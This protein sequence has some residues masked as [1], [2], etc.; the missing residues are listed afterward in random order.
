MMNFVKSSSGIGSLELPII[1]YEDD[2]SH[3]MNTTTCYIKSDITMHIPKKFYPHAL[4]RNGETH[5]LQVKSCNNI[6]DS[7]VFDISIILLS[8]QANILLFP[9]NMGN[10]LYVFLD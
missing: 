10:N 7:Y 3:I 8:F 4:Q 9:H 2:V 6:G 5:I 1:M